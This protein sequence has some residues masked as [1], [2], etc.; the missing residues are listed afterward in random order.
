M[1]VLNMESSV[2]SVNCVVTNKISLIKIHKLPE[3]VATLYW[4][5]PSQL[6]LVHNYV[7]HNYD[8]LILLYFDS[9][10]KTCY[11]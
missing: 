8:E 1:M 10:D 7:K 6:T 9:K 11:E 5:E 3:D 2:R 4:T